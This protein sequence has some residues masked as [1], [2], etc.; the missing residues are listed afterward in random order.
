MIIGC[1]VDGVIADLHPEWLRRYNAEYADNMQVAD[2]VC[3][4]LHTLVRPACGKK[5]YSYLSAPDLYERVLP[6]DGA[7]FGVGYLRAMGHRVV[8]I[9]SNAKG[10]TDQKW[11]WLERH[12]FLPAGDTAPDLVCATDKSLFMIDAMIEDYHENL[13]F[14]QAR[15]RILLT[16]P[17]NASAQG[18]WKRV[19]SWREVCDQIKAAA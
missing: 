2:I 18:P 4:G 15:C 19:W 1:D 3:W 7:R 10:M 16:R 12:G 11:A 9:T 8:F 6:L 17:W 5:I 13:L 14:S